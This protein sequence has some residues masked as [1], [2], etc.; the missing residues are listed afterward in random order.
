MAYDEAL[1]ERIRGRLDREP[2]VVEKRMFGGLAFLVEGN[3]CVGVHRDDL[4]A[5]VGPERG[6]ALL[7]RPGTRVF[8]ITG[9]PMKNWLLVSHEVL[10]DDA[11]LGE[12][13][14]EALAFARSLP[15]K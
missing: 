6:D 7:A 15:P 2:G 9:R 3:M 1:A 5:R 12:W 14:G 10:D 8:D 4:I 11:E 13:I